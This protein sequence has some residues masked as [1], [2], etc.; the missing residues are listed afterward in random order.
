MD[1]EI[2]EAP[3]HAVPLWTEDEVAFVSAL[4]SDA[5]DVL[6]DEQSSPSPPAS[7]DDENDV[8]AANGNRSAAHESA[9]KKKTNKLSPEER[10]AARRASHRETMRRSR[11]R[12]R[13][14]IAAMMRTVQELEG[15]RAQVLEQQQQQQQ[16]AD[17]GLQGQVA[18]LER[19]R[20]QLLD[21]NDALHTQLVDSLLAITRAHP[22]NFEHDQVQRRV[23]GRLGDKQG[24]DGT[25]FY[26]MNTGNG[27]VVK[28]DPVTL[29]DLVTWD[30][31]TI[32]H[33]LQLVRDATSEIAKFYTT[34]A[35]EKQQQVAVDMMGWR[36]LRRALV[37]QD[38]CVEFAFDK[39]FAG[40]SPGQLFNKTWAF[41][42]N[43]RQFATMLE[44]VVHA[45]Q[46]EVL[47]QINDD[48]VVVRRMQQELSPEGEKQT[49]TK[50]RSI[51]L[52]YR[53]TS[54]AGVFVVLQS[55][56]PSFTRRCGCANNLWF[57]SFLWFG[58]LPAEASEN[59]KSSCRVRFGGSLDGHSEEFARRWQREIF[60][61]VLRWETHNVAPVVL[62]PQSDST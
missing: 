31:G 59:G 18:R 43:Q 5:P 26:V 42:R 16:R 55:V 62:L 6:S 33:C 1:V 36:Q 54:P 13:D 61:M 44:P 39:T 30:V 40:Y 48:I 4:L 11:Q 50:Y 29:C 28:R 24:G 46:L 19:Q 15:V 52:L 49:P 10:A 14:Q 34:V 22:D 51:Y 58:F 56:N 3:L 8:Q 37:K 23:A 47:Q 12:F 32:G 35:K 25:D 45:L 9:K 60:F 20:Q 38:T 17:G 53:M 21:E 7:V 2:L 41:C 57:E 27:A